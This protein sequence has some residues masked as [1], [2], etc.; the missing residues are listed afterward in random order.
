MTQ[1]EYN[2]MLASAREQF[3]Q[4]TPLFGKEGAFHRI[5]EDFLN[6]ALEGE[7][8]SHLSVTK[9]QTKNRR[10]GKMCKTLQTEY[11]QVEIETPRDR[12][13]S[14]SPEIVQKRQTILA[15]GLSDKIISLYATGQRR[16]SIT[17]RGLPSVWD[18]P[19]SICAMNG[20]LLRRSSQGNTNLLMLC[21]S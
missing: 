16:A 2:S 7:M 10:N 19:Q 18:I 11:G 9:A 1:E 21:E 4:G 15:E 14:F 12:D 6:C 13:G 3:K 20:L 17:L 8:E 5:L